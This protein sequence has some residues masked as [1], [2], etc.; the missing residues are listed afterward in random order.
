M[1]ACQGGDAAVRG[2]LDEG[3]GNG[4]QKNQQELGLKVWMGTRGRGSSAETRELGCVRHGAPCG[5]LSE[6]GGEP[7]EAGGQAG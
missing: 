7:P 6:R 2:F 4:S 5:W 1:G 3:A